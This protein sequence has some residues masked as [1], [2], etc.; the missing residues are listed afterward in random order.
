MKIAVIIFVQMLLLSGAGLIDA[1]SLEKTI[2]E[3]FDPL[4]DINIT[5]EILTIRALYEIDDLSEADFFAKVCINDQKF[6]SE[7]WHN[8]KYIYDPR[9]LV[10]LDVPDD[11]EFVTVKIELWNSNDEDAICD[12][13][14][15]DD[16]IEL[17]YSIKTGR[18]TGDDQLGDPSGYGRLC[19]CDDGSIYGDERDCEIWFNIYQN[20]FDNDEIPYWIE[21]NEYG[22]DPEID[23]TN[24]DT[25]KDGIP[26][27]WEHTWGYNP[28]EA[29]DH[30]NID[31][32]EDSIN[33][34]EEYLTSAF[35]SDPFRQDIFL[36][37]DWMEEG[38]NGEKSVIPE[39][40]KDC[41]KNPFHR[42]NIVFHLDTGE[43]NGSELISFEDKTNQTTLLEIYND[44]FTHNI[45][46]NW[47]RGVFHYAIIVNL[48]DMKG[49][50]FS[51]DTAPYW[52]YIPGT[53]GFVI[54]SSQMEKNTKKIIYEDKTLE[55]FYGSAMMHEMGHNFGIRFGEPI[56]CDN[57][58]AK[59]PW[60]IS[61]WLIRNYRSIMNYQ[62][63]YRI[64]DYSDGSH[65]WND[66]NDWENIDLKY[67]EQP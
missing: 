9:F 62:Y 28:I 11:Q 41:L 65:G 56:G 59:Y 13:G 27:K 30:K 23:N 1:L 8:T 38:P 48:C 44:Y 51:G 26:L 31:P 2:V 36:E 43:E 10:T 39:K 6:T 25:D 42:R 21:V 60:Q 55:N 50:A 22:T 40:A 14:N 29:D 67:F 32:D 19:G 53:N 4:V 57:W 35:F 45:E 63:T 52:G 34:Y 3:D 49:Y 33:N 17:Q 18:W 20:D 61:F 16:Y 7:I 15:E 64:F 54:S 47:R 46:N 66:Y 5:V 37:V 24:D 12:I 58:F